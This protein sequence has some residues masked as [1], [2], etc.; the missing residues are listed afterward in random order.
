MRSRVLRAAVLAGLGALVLSTHVFVEIDRVRVK[1]LGAATVASAAGLAVVHVNTAAFPEVNLLR[2]PF[3]LIARINS[4]TAGPSA[5][6][7]SVDDARTCERRVAAG[8]IRRID[9]TV[10]AGWNRTSE[11]NVAIQGP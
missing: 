4:Q 10:S 5:F 9:C 6:H 3:A 1:L 11:H 7:V 2:P 8:G